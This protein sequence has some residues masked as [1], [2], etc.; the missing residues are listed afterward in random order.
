MFDAISQYALE[1]L[2]GFVAKR[3]KRSRP[4]GHEAGD[5]RVTGQPRADHLVRNR[6]RPQAL[7][8]LA[9]TGRTPTVKNVG[10]PCAGEP[11]ARFDGEGLETEPS[12]TA[13]VP[14]PTANSVG[15]FGSDLDFY[16]VGRVAFWLRQGQRDRSADELEG[17]PLG[18]GRLG[19]HRDGD[20]GSG[21]ADLVAGQR[22]Q[23]LQQAAEAAVGLPGRVVLA[24][25]LGLRRRGAAGRGDRVSLLRR[26][27][28]GE[29][30]R[31]PGPAQVPVRC[32][33]SAWPVS[34]SDGPGP[35]VGHDDHPCPSACSISSSSGS[36][37]G[38]SCSAGHR[39]QRTRNCSCCGMRSPC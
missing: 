30:Q 18:A 8:A 13:P 32:Q 11:H 34:C 25:R 14:H 35:A 19:E 23:V 12:A 17:P 28:V 6:H 38:W 22:G 1:R 31:G 5:L 10:E 9:G 20:L 33:K 27:L 39:P 29:G 26:V 2:A 7:P 4:L 37:A 3:H 24:G 16:R 21:V 36:A 15:D